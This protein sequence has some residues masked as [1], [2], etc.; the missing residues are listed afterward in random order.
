MEEKKIDSRSRRSH[1][2]SVDL[3][4]IGRARLGL[5]D[6]CDYFY[7]KSVSFYSPLVIT[8]VRSRSPMAV[9]CPGLRL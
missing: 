2:F 3:Q 9:E 1:H 8:H 4:N 5:R 6:R 7:V